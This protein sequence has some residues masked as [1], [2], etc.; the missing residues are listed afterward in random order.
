M[1]VSCEVTFQPFVWELL[2]A[3]EIIANQNNVNRGVP[4]SPQ[5]KISIVIETDQDSIR[6]NLYDTCF[7]TIDDSISSL[8]M[9]QNDCS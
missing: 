8:S 6:P 7:L 3:A 1:N 4:Q 9:L 5:Y 2:F